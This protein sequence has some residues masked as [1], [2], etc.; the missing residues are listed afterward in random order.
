VSGT[1][2][3]VFGA[4]VSPTGV[5]LLPL[6]RRLRV[7]AQEAARAPDAMVIVSGGR[8][9]GR[10]AEAPAMRDWLV[11]AGVAEGRIVLEPQAGSTLENARRCADIVA[12]GRIRTVMLVTERYHLRRARLLLCRALARRRLRIELRVCAAADDLSAR[13]RLRT[14]AVEVLKLARD[15]LAGYK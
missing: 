4:A 12:S 13:E 14:T 10:P 3:V 9:H 1:A 5:P 15:L 6:I 7:A 2:I 11:A 8:V